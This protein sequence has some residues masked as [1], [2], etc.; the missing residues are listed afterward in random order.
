MGAPTAAFGVIRRLTLHNSK[1]S[2]FPSPIFQIM[3]PPKL[4]AIKHTRNKP[5]MY[6]TL[7]CWRISVPQPEPM[8]LD[9]HE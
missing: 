1:R 8:R 5:I 9:R 6:A 3:K 7:I 2:V 4:A